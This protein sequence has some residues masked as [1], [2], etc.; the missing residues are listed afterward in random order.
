[1]RTKLASLIG[2]LVAGLLLPTSGTQ[3]AII[4]YTTRAAFTAAV[5]GATT[6]EDFT[7]SPHFPIS[8]GILNSATNIPSIGITPGVIL[9]GVTYSTPVATGNFFNIDGGAGGYVGGFLDSVVGLKTLTITFDNPQVGFGFDTA[10]LMG[11]F[12]VQIF[13]GAT[14]LSNQTFSGARFYGFQDSS[15]DITSV[16]ITGAAAGGNVIGF[17]LDN[18]TYNATPTVSAVPVPAALPL[19]ATGLAGLGLLGWRRKKAAG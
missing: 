18:F 15:A 3:A 8:T 4:D 7:S 14:V 12:N 19:F 10:D 13:S 6:V 16:T 1:V 17:D 11:S 2:C 9:P 5:P